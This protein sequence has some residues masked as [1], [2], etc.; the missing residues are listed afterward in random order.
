MINKFKVLAAQYSRQCLDFPLIAVKTAN[1]CDGL[2]RSTS[3]FMKMHRS[4]AVFSFVTMPSVTLSYLGFAGA[5]EIPGGWALGPTKRGT[6]IHCDN[7]NYVFLLNPIPPG[8]FE[9]G[10]A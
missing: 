8:L 7:L 9:G 2:S 3:V 6:T 4:S 5:A 1:M 10:S